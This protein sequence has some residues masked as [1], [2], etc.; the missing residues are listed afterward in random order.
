MWPRRHKHC[1]KSLVHATLVTNA[2]SDVMKPV[3]KAIGKAWSRA[4]QHYASEAQQAQQSGA[5]RLK[6]GLVL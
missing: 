4:I 1:F 6:P 5:V 2:G 3:A